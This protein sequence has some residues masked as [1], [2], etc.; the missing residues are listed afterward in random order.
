MPVPPQGIATDNPQ[1][2]PAVT[3]FE[4]L[5]HSDPLFVAASVS[6]WWHVHTL[7]HAAT[8]SLNVGAEK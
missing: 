3:A 4:P 8:H 6:E 7:T 5:A 2:R 1:M